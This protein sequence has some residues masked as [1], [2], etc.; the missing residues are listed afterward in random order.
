MAKAPADRPT[1]FVVRDAFIIDIDGMPVAYRTG[2]P[3]DPDDPVIRTHAPFLRPLV[4]PHPPK[5]AAAAAA[6]A[7]T[8]PEVRAD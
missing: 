8:T 6:P 4:Y 3:I 1:V 7:L 5:R 2:E